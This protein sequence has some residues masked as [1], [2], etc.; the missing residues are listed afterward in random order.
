MAQAN[1]NPARSADGGRTAR[2]RRSVAVAD[3]L[4]AAVPALWLAV[5]FLLP[6]A[7]TFVFSFGHSLFGGVE[8]GFTLDNYRLALSG[9]YGATF[10]RTLRFAV[11]A[12]AL[13][14][15]VAFPAA[16]F[17]AR[18]S[19]RR[20]NVALLLILIPYFSSFLIR[21]MAL[22]MLMARGGVVEWL[23]NGVGLHAGPLDLLDT[24]T[25]VFIGMVYAYLP[26]A[27]IPLVVVLDR[28]P[29]ALVEAS[30]DLGASRWRTFRHVTLPLTRPGI[31][32][33]ALLTAVPMLGELVIPRLL[34]GGRGL[35]M[36]QAISSQY[37]QS[38]NY[39][40]GSA[41]AVLVLV[42]VGVLVA[43][44]ARM[45]KGFVEVPR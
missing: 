3:H 20:K 21:I 27:I 11:T 44:L 34:G 33:A 39:P 2:P 14:L 28:I 16:L 22:T 10:L 18:L 4:I 5:F 6:L 7:F 24:Q 40:L 23:L 31:A 42:A 19:G 26:I 30:R 15:A 41:M 12:S 38:Q 36:G 45:T 8:L 1:G 35:L 43:A 32:T 29:R 25:A 17:I 13:C 37:L 9:F